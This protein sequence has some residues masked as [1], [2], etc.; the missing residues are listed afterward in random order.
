M[1]RWADEPITFDRSDTIHSAKAK[2]DAAGT[3]SPVVI[4][5]PK[6]HIADNVLMYRLLARTSQR[7]GTPIAIVANS[8]YWR[9]LAREHGLRAFP[10]VGAV[11][12]SRSRSAASV[13]ENLADT[14][15]SYLSPSFSRQGWAMLAGL[16]LVVAAVLYLFVPDMTVT[17]ATP[18][19]EIN[20]EIQVRVDAS[21]TS[22]DVSSSL[23]PGRIIEYRFPISDTVSTTG[24]KNVGKDKATGEVTV[25]NGTSSVVVIPAG[26]VLSTSTGQKFTTTSAVVL[27]SPQQPARIA[28]PTPSPSLGTFP[29]PGAFATP[30]AFPTVIPQAVPSPQSAPNV[31]AGVTAKI[32]VVAVDA[33]EAGNVPALAISKF[34]SSSFAGLTVLNE[35]PLSGGTDNKVKVASADDRSRL[36]EELVQRAQ[37]QALAELQARVRQSE[38]LIPHSMQVRIEQETYDKNVD[39]QGDQLNGTLSVDATA[40]AFNNSDLNT[41]V[42]QQWKESVPTGFRA[43]SAP[44]DI[45]PPE[46]LQ[47][48]SQTASLKVAVS[49]MAQRVLEANALSQSLRGLSVQEARAKLA[50]LES[51]LRVVNLEIWPSWAG[52]AFRVDVR[53]VQ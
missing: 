12:R 24:E 1:P 50:Q 51:P 33:G 10:S 39:E 2:L 11:G 25:I 23:I 35:Q 45:N 31:I 8:P 17:I 49:G 7:L 6:C 53:T 28:L 18:V 29:T 30:G 43:T 5:D 22:L 20:Q 38:S 44:L 21:I 14:I 34:D 47:A 32:P 15:F 13:A 40:I 26:S 37:S 19:Q 36:K 4:L 48:G 46:V 42:E 3:G 41:V 9:K 16:L 52:H 27:S